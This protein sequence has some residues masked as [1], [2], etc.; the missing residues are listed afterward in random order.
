MSPSEPTA[1]NRRARTKTTV[2]AIETMAPTSDQGVATKAITATITATMAAGTQRCALA[3]L[4]DRHAL[5]VVHDQIGHAL[6]G[7][8]TVEE[9]RDP[10]MAESAVVLRI[11]CTFVANWRNILHFC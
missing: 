11:V 1:T 9:S 10:G 5:D 2:T 6:F 3:V 4:V 8:A 7:L